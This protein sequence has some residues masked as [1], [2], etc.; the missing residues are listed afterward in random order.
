MW[1][2][3]QVEESSVGVLGITKKLFTAWPLLL[4][5][6]FCYCCGAVVIQERRVYV[7][8]RSGWDLSC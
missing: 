3:C 7:R 1:V 4:I 6:G 8:C 5:Q 2:T